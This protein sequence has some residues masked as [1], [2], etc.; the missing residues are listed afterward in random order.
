MT[1]IVQD[2]TT[3]V[4]AEV[5]GFKLKLITGEHAGEVRML[6]DVKIFEE[7]KHDEVASV[8]GS[9]WAS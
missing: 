2:G 1:L 7:V 6:Q 5:K 8:L 4:G 9:I 3:F